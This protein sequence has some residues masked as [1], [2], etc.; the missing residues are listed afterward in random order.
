M[1]KRYFR[2]MQL[3]GDQHEFIPVKTLSYPLLTE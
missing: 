2:C 1:Q 3:K